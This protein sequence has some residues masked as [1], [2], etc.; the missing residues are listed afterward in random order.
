MS[1]NPKSDLIRIGVVAVEPIRLAGLTSIFDLPAEQGQPQLLPVVGTLAELLADHT[2][3]YL[4]FDLHASLVG[5]EAL[6]S[7]RRLRPKLRL[8]VIG[9]EGDEELVISSIVA[10]ARAYL[11]LTADPE[12]VRQAVNVVTSG[13]IWA[14]RRLLSR[15]IDRL[16]NVPDTSLTNAGPQ[17][18]AREQQVLDLI[19]LARSNREIAAELGIEERTVKAYV[20][21]LLRKTGAGNRIK[22]SMSALNRSLFTRENQADSSETGVGRKSAN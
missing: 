15:L 7:V 13:S 12:M 16:L 9:P 19:L 4:V 10:G 17:L 6:E 14:P 21:R 5:L 2:L 18:T 1:K 3:G 11:D 20:G 8:I 22:L